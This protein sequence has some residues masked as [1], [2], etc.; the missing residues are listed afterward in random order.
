MRL[1]GK[2]PMELMADQDRADRNSRCLDR[3]RGETWFE[4]LS[5]E[6]V[7]DVAEVQAE[8]RVAQKYRILRSRVHG[9]RR[10][11]RRILRKSRIEIV[12]REQNHGGD[13]W[14][15]CADP[16]RSDIETGIS[17]GHQ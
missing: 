16:A 13:D 3:F 11:G 7:V 2:I 10:W 8:I 9:L 14:D 17:S 5:G 12:Q 4:L 1:H 15:E 6:P